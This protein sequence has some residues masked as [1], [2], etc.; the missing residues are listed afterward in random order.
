[1]S[2][3]NTAA[4]VLGWVLHILHP[5]YGQDTLLNALIAILV[6]ITAKSNQQQYDL[7]DWSQVLSPA[8]HRT[9]ADAGNRTCSYTGSIRQVCTIRS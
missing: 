7:G 6:S 4:P 1:M 5:G 2:V 8:L 9:T 3:P